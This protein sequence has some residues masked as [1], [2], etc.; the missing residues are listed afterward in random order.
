[1]D[2]N[3]CLLGEG[4]LSAADTVADVVTHTTSSGTYTEITFDDDDDTSIDAD[5]DTYDDTL[6]GV[7]WIVTLSV[8][9]DGDAKHLVEY[10]EDVGDFVMITGFATYSDG[11]KK[12]TVDDQGTA[13]TYKMHAEATY[14]NS[15]DLENVVELT[16]D[17]AG[18]VT[19]L[20]DVALDWIYE[21]GEYTAEVYALGSDSV[22]LKVY[23]PAYFLDTDFHYLVADGPV[24]YDGTDYI[25]LAGLEAG[26]DVQMFFSDLDG[27]ETIVYLNIDMDYE[28]PF[29]PF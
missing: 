4:R 22:V 23:A 17:G 3:R 21:D 27:P 7:D 25:G 5:P 11:S 1:L 14:P 29:G 12:V 6:P 20:D 2:C 16:T 10:G 9:F 8:N 13:K 28:Y 19:G 18:E 15:G 24:V 26:D